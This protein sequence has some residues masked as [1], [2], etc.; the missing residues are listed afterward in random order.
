M[1]TSE[2]RT[3]L[4]SPKDIVVARE[5]ARELGSLL[6]MSSIGA[7]ELA[8]AISEVAR[9]A[10][11]YGGGGEVVLSQFAEAKR[12]G[13]RVTVEDK[14]PGIADIDLAMK[15]GYSTGESLGLGL[16]GARR[17][18]DKFEIVS[19]VGMGTRVTMTKWAS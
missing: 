17:L 8:T 16:P 9:N 13:I 3:A 19:K 4:R 5:Y 15:D 10:L 2:R 7:T 12:R 18:V 6:G 1:Q 11:T 14:G